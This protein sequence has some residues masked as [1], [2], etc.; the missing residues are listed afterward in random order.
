MPSLAVSIEEARQLAQLA[1]DMG[2]HLDMLRKYCCGQELLELVEKACARHSD[3]G[4]LENTLQNLRL[5]ADLATRVRRHLWEWSHFLA[6]GPG[7]CGAP[8]RTAP[9]SK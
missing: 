6:R 2:V 3:T 8:T 7:L 9:T 5:A 4:M 1:S